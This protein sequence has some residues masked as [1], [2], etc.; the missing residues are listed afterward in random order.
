M[1]GAGGSTPGGTPSRPLRSRRAQA[2]SPAQGAAPAPRSEALASLGALAGDLAHEIRN[3]LVAVK[4][5]LELLPG[6]RGDPEVETRFL[7]IAREELRR[8]ERLLDAM[9][10]ARRGRSGREPPG[11]VGVAVDA[12]TTLLGP[13]AGARGVRLETFVEPRLPALALGPDALRQVLLNLAMNAVDASPRDGRI[14]IRAREVGEG[15]EISLS[16]EGPGLPAAGR[17]PP[18]AGLRPGGLGLAITRRLL[19]AA[20]G[21][22]RAG[23]ASGGGTLVRAWAP[24]LPRPR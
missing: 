17:T 18:R 12:V 21:T 3:P 23:S 7:E 9:I 8:A 1:N 5:F 14:E 10:D 22:L 13:R 11:E 20:G 2:G 6:H 16:D 4:S 24:A 19:A 15:V